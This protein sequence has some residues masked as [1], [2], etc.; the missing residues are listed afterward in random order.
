MSMRHASTGIAD[1]SALKIKIQFVVEVFWG[2]QLSLTGAC[3]TP[4]PSS[5][6]LIQRTAGGY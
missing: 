1:Q 4:T 2:F 6:S 5:H 3:I